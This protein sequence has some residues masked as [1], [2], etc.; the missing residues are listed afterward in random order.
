MNLAA[1]LLMTTAFAL[2][3]ST[4]TSQPNSTN[5]QSRDT[6]PNDP[7]HRVTEHALVLHDSTRDKDLHIRIV[8]ALNAATN[9]AVPTI[10]FS[11]GA[12]GSGENYDPLAQFWATHGYI[13]ILPTHSDSLITPTDPITDRAQSRTLRNDIRQ[14][15][16]DRKNRLNG[17]DFSDW[18]NRPR[19]ISFII[20][21]LDSIEQQIPSIQHRI[22]HSRLGV[23]GHSFG[24]FT[25]QLIAGTDPLGVE[26]FHDPRAICTLL[27]SPQ[28][29]GGLLTNSSWDNFQGPAL[30][31]TGD[32]DQGRNGEPAVWRRDAFDHSPPNTHTLL[33]INDAYHNFGGISGTVLP[34]PD[35][36]PENPIHVQLVQ[37]STLSFWDHHLKHQ[38][39]DIAEFAN[40]LESQI[41][42]STANVEHN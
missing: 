35:Q 34:L 14:R 16:K 28:G 2:S 25:A 32:N 23:G 31:I 4:A 42:S 24:A 29:I 36:G 39:R 41:D 3:C 20:D 37:N 11:H 13:V 19:D 40:L 8:H 10:I 6:T 17:F 5:T 22:D 18:A 38:S 9:T 7:I 1:T 15:L 33:W 30:T 21:Q 27:I 26:D 12:G